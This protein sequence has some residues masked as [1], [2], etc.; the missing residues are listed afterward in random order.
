[1][2]QNGAPNREA[3][4]ETNFQERLRTEFVG[5]EVMNSSDFETFFGDVSNQLY[6]WIETCFDR[7]F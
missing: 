3:K 1:M 6:R 4:N 5:R 2:C 7:F